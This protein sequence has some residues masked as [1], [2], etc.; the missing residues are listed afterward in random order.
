MIKEINIGAESLQRTVPEIIATLRH[1][2]VHY[3]CCVNNI[4]DT[5]RNG[6]YHNERFKTECE[7]RGLGQ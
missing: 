2:M 7:K 3:Y 4:K 1:E 6:A 5:S